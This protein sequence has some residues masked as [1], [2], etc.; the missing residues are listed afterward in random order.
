MYVIVGLPKCSVSKLFFHL[1]ISRVVLTSYCRF[2]LH[3][4]N[5]K[6]MHFL[7]SNIKLKWSYH[8][9]SFSIVFWYF[10]YNASTNFCEKLV[11]A[12][13]FTI[14][15]HFRPMV[16]YLLLQVELKCKNKSTLL[17]STLFSKMTSNST[18]TWWCSQWMHWGGIIF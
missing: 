4:I 16:T 6:N 3:F 11:R 10:V 13:G 1:Q 2:Q 14:Q 8:F 12:Y 7:L 5:E 9:L 15:M 18:W 17:L